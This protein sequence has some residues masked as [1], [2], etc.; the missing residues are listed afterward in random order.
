MKLVVGLKHGSYWQLYA[1]APPD[2]YND[3]IKL[4]GYYESFSLK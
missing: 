4:R 3:I 1:D 2:N